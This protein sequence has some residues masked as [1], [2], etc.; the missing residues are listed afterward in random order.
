VVACSCQPTTRGCFP[1]PSPHFRPSLQLQAPPGRTSCNGKTGQ[2]H[3]AVS[4]ADQ[5]VTKGTAFLQRI[6]TAPPSLERRLVAKTEV[7]E[8]LRVRRSV[9]LAACGT[10]RR[11]HVRCGEPRPDLVGV[12]QVGLSVAVALYPITRGRLFRRLPSRRLFRSASWRALRGR[13]VRGG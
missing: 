1:A 3:A 7:S 5:L 6:L 9:V 8:G 13:A 4:A 12:E 2:P 11:A 10:A